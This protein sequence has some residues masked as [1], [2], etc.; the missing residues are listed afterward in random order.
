MS[1]AR[2]EILGRIR[3][4]LRDVPREEQPEDV[5]VERGY[6]RDGG[7]PLEAVIARFAERTAEYRA[8]VERVPKDALQAAVAHACERHAA[9]R[10]VVPAGVPAKARPEGI[11]LVPDEGLG[12]ADLDAIDGVLTGCAAAIAD[13]GTIVLDAGP[14]QGRRE[15]TLVPDLHIC[16]VPAER[17][18]GSVP[19]GIARVAGAVRDEQRPITFISGPSATSDI[20]LRR[21]EGVH[22]P[23]KLVVLVVE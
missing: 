21:V 7:E 15:L 12:A 4:A 1:G 19:E 23:R 6:R 3:T 16:I 10:L 8:E 22:G 5:R 17:V 11:E 9:R 2:E 18:V 20:E 14:D 13:T